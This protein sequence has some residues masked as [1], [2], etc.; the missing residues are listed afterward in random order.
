MT[1]QGPSPGPHGQVRSGAGCHQVARLPGLGGP[2]PH[3]P[4]WPLQRF[5]LWLRPCRGLLEA[6]SSGWQLHAGSEPGLCYESGGKM[7]AGTRAAVCTEIQQK[8]EELERVLLAFLGLN[9]N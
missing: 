3:T 2:C 5:T 6:C 4:R 7:A 9:V 1:E 8:L